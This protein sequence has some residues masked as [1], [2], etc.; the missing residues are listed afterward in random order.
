[1]DWPVTLYWLA[2]VFVAM[3]ACGRSASAR[4]VLGVFWLAW[5]T[6]RFGGPVEVLYLPL[7]LGGLV[8]AAAAVRTW[9]G[10]FGAILFAP[11]ALADVLHLAGLIDAYDWWWSV[12]WLAMVQIASLA[13]KAWETIRE[14]L[15]GR[16]ERGK[17]TGLSMMGAGW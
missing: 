5:L 2:I 17:D 4:A 13:P 6:A 7:H 12:W 15:P 10:L 9:P 11:L 14:Y 16:A 8:Y 1:M 3:P